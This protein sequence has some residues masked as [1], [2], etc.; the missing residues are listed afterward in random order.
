MGILRILDLVIGI[1]FIYFILSIVASAT[2]EIV[3]NFLMFR[4]ND[5]RDW[6]YSTFNQPYNYKKPNFIKRLGISIVKKINNFL[7]KKDVV[8]PKCLGEEI[9]H[10]FAIDGLSKA[11]KKV[12]YIPSSEFVRALFDIV[13]T[14]KLKDINGNYLY[15]NDLI[16]N[17]G[18]PILAED[19]NGKTLVDENGKPLTKL[20]QVIKVRD[21]TPK[22]YSTDELS[23]AVIKTAF[24]SND[25]ASIILQYIKDGYNFYEVRR[26]FEAWF[27]HAMER[28]S[29]DYKRFSQRFLFFNGLFIAF[30]FNV[31]TIAL[32]NYLYSNPDKSLVFANAISNSFNDPNFHM[33]LQ[34][35]QN[36]RERGTT[37][38]PANIDTLVEKVSHFRELSKSIQD[39]DFPLGWKKEEIQTSQTNGSAGIINP[40]NKIDN[41]LN[42]ILGILITGF[43]LSLGA[44]FW[45]DLLNKLVNLRSAGKKPNETY[46]DADAIG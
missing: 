16:D 14:V 45:F 30:L 28:L 33:A 35:L 29:G 2:L 27:D 4:A 22:I 7:G 26:G 41:P 10:H 15:R 24:L 39:P 38:N 40:F 8:E 23:E 3:A 42:S 12:S 18:N 31:D 44:T 6:V 1:I 9:W 25:Q 46:D 37:I 19:N 32:S 36:S 21:I 20:Q 34:N 11:G 5:L 17:L 13:V 43:A